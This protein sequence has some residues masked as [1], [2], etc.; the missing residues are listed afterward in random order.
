MEVSLF[1][2]AGAAV[3]SS[4]RRIG[5]RLSLMAMLALTP[6]VVSAQ[7][8]IDNADTGSDAS[9][10]TAKTKLFNHL[11]LSVTL[12]TTG[13]GFDVAMPVNKVVQL[14]AGFVFMPSVDV[15]MNFGIQMG[16]EQISEAEM[17]EKFESLSSFFEEMTG[18][19]IDKSID[20]VGTPT[21][22]N[23]K[24]LVDVFPFHDKHWHFSGGF[25]WGPS[26]IAKAVNDV[27]DAT[28]LVALSIYNSLYDR[29]IASYNSYGDYPYITINGTSLYAGY[30]LA[31]KFMEY[32]KLGVH[33]GD[34]KDTGNPYRMVPDENN[35]VTAKI[36]V[37]SF[38][39]YIGFGY[40]GRLFK[41]NDDYYVSFDC[42]VMFWGG[43]PAI[44]TTTMV[45]TGE[46]D[47]DDPYLPAYEKKQV[48]L[49]KDVRN[50]G[51]KV[52][53]YVDI[54][55]AFKVYPE[56]SVRFTRRIF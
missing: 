17:D 46:M 26:R 53:D 3:G 50:I 48:D 42:G 24:F 49:A 5:M 18:T 10:N 25:F 19:K 27:N 28:S 35:T 56:I 7:G 8:I 21:F 36:K 51:G 13:I 43:T 22:K 20:M 34:Y 33:V 41:N 30:D 12:G 29:V 54:I 45:E 14:R 6:S 39:P 40:G 44:L 38:R 31:E 23:F 47:A 9:G 1:H 2:I 32:G 52:G 15:D 4:M 16:D 55:K 37:N 11:D